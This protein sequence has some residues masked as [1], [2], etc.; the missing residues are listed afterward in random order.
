MRMWERSLKIG[1][2]VASWLLPSFTII[3]GILAFVPGEVAAIDM[4]VRGPIAVAVLI[5]AAFCG[6]CVLKQRS[7]R[8]AIDRAAKDKTDASITGVANHLLCMVAEQC[9]TSGSWRVTLLEETLSVS[10]ET[11]L[12]RV[13]RVAEQPRLSD[14]GTKEFPLRQ[15]VLQGMKA[16]EL[17]DAAA[18]PVNLRVN[19]PDPDENETSWRKEQERFVGDRAKYLHMRSRAYGWR[20]IAPSHPGQSLYVLLV[21]TTNP[22]GISRPGLE[23]A[24]LDSI[25][26]ALISALG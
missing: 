2:S 19:F 8:K 4:R 16:L 21:E 9:V 13:W 26:R 3:A 10:G 14:G 22:Q 17:N 20:R 15:S 1:E 12:A 7:R 23:N 24:F 6:F 25:A 18:P 11:H 5:V